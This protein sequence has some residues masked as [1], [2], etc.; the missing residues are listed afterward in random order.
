M[1]KLS[2]TLL[3]FTAL[4]LFAQVPN[5]PVIAHE[6]PTSVV[7][8]QPLRIVARVSSEDTIKEVNLYLAQSGGA[9][10]AKLRL[11]SAGAGVYSAQIPAAQFAGVSKFRY[12]LDA[13]TVP[14]A[15]TETNWM[16]VQVIGKTPATGSSKE[17]SWKRPVL[18][19]AG[20]VV[21]VGAGIAIAGSGGGGDGDGG[22]NSGSSDPADNILV[23]TSSD[24]A[25]DN[26][27]LLP[28]AQIVDIAGDLAGRSIS[29]VRIQLE[30]N[31]ID[32]GAE[33]YEVKYNG[34][35]VISGRTG[36]SITEQVDVVGT[37]DTQVVISVTDSEAVD[38]TQSF[39]WNATVTYF[40][41]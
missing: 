19:G 37:S 13:R 1:K 31:G 4:N 18:I 6:P 22:G 25:N 26:S 14:G 5:R 36:G 29:R 8:G 30:F 16:T 33:E 27:V 10:P 20:A 38:G 28:R 41:E 11:Q 12:Y 23:R 34:A 15:V 24:Q 2:L 9:A 32:G 39:S 21:A 3:C 40:V 7:A 35:T 17:S